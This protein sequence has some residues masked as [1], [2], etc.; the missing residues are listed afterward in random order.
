MS[1]EESFDLSRIPGLGPRRRQ[2][3]EAA[4]ITDIRELLAMKT[5][6]L[7][8]IR[9]IGQWQ[10]QRIRE[11]LR[12][13]GILV[14][15]E[16]EQG[17]EALVAVPQTVEEAVEVSAAVEELRE[18]AA[19]EAQA[20]A[21]V[22]LL[23]AVVAHVELAEEAPAP[24]QAP[25]VEEAPA[26]TKDADPPPADSPVAEPEEPRVPEPDVWQ[27]RFR[28]ERDMVPTAALDLFEAIRHAA[29]ARELTRQIT[30]FLIRSGECLSEDRELSSDARAVAEACVLEVEQI[31]KKAVERSDFTLSRQ[32]AVAERIRRRR[33]ALEK[34]LGK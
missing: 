10:A 7:A 13:R 1:Q 5:A 26:A 25:S 8:A 28:R 31:L 11:H 19:S 6:E 33:R 30:R 24:E 22:A 17:H 9:G 2:A 3:L 29:V 15:V 27:G 23:E 12:Q 32:R 34:L 18:N 14:E 16:D 4:G 21:E 20:A